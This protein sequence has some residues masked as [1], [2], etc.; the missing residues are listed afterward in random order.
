MSMIVEST[1]ILPITAA[2]AFELLRRS[3]TLAKVAAGV[4]T[5][6][7][8]AL[9]PKYWQVDQKVNL[10]PRLRG[11]PQGDHYVTFT[12]IDEG[13]RELKTEE[14]GGP[15]KSWKHTMILRDTPVGTCFYTDHIV[16][17]A[18]WKTLWIWL[19]AKFFYRHRQK[20]WLKLLA[21]GEL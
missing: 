18:G 7:T 21:N 12:T 13:K 3:D 4:M 5:Y 17:D 19:F 16:I 20:R 15:I 2:K 14:F 8:E 1:V 9:W 10:K 6:D 11:V